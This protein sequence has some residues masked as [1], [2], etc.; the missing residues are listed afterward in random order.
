MTQHLSLEQ[1]RHLSTTMFAAAVRPELWSDVV[2]DL[3]EVTGGVRPHIVGFDLTSRVHLGHVAH[4]FDPDF[5]ATFLDHYHKLNPWI[6]HSVEEPVGKAMS[7]ACMCSDDVLEGTE[8]YN[9]WVRPQEDCLGGGGAVIHRSATQVF[10]M[11]GSIRRRD[12][13]ALEGPFLDTL[14]ALIPPALHAWKVGTVMAEAGLARSLG[15]AA[16]HPGVATLV[17]DARGTLLHGN[18]VAIGLLASGTI[19]RADARNRVRLRDEAAQQRIAGHLD[20]LRRG[21]A[22]SERFGLVGAVGG[23]TEVTVTGLM[24]RDWPDDVAGELFFG[25]GQPVLI[26]T[27]QLGLGADTRPELCRRYGMTE[28][29]A[30][31]TVALT[32][33]LT[34]EEIA[35]AREVSLHTVRNQIKSA[36]GKCG[37]SRQT[38]LVALAAR[39]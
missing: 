17:L 32:E 29:E 27:L 39:L 28:A 18:A 36:M 3:F 23:W 15:V 14:Q 5:E 2:A 31:V 4:G 12:R 25:G 35:E 11:G 33:G 8:F 6:D 19:L 38:Q 13:D 24:G 26:L 9:D 20:S 1:F 22:P 34:P 21:D 7:S 10:K 37:V 30:A 16:V